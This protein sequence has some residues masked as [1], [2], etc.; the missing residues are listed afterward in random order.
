MDLFNKKWT[1]DKLRD[2]VRQALPPDYGIQSDDEGIGITENTALLA[3]VEL[4]EDGKE[5]TVVFSA[6][7]WPA[8]AAVLALILND[9][10]PTLI[11]AEV[12]F[13]ASDIADIKEAH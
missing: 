11:E 2:A 10:V 9:I 8:F 6:T 5:V 13:V 3:Y 1:V 12:G 7:I 4:S